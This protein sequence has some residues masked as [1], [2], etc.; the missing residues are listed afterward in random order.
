M[1]TN[2]AAESCLS[3]KNSKTRTKGEDTFTGRLRKIR[4]L[5]LR[6][7]DL[8]GYDIETCKGM[9]QVADISMEAIVKGLR[10]SEDEM[11]DIVATQRRKLGEM[12]LQTKSYK[13]AVRI[14]LKEN[15]DLRDTLESHGWLQDNLV[16]LDDLV[17]TYI[18]PKNEVA[19]DG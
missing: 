9:Q 12:D 7:A 8:N 19:A 5:N 14:L 16:N 6:E 4:E 15:L 13:E 1:I 2:L 17:N 3:L 10:L 18:L 11:S